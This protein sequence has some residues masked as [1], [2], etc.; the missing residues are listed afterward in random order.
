MKHSENIAEIAAALAKA[1]GVMAKAKRSGV[2]DHFRSRY[3]MLDDL[4]EVAR[5][6]LS[7][8]S[9]A[10]VQSAGTDPG[11]GLARVSTMLL[12]SSGQWMQSTVEYPVEGNVQSLGSTFTYLRRQSLSS[13]L[14]ISCDVD[15]DGEASRISGGGSSS[16]RPTPPPSPRARGP[17]LNTSGP[18]PAQAPEPAGAEVGDGYQVVQ[19]TIA[20]VAARPTDNGGTRYAVELEGFD[21]RWA[22]TFDEKLGEYAK[23]R[24]G[25]EVFAEVKRGPKRR[26][27]SGYLW[28]LVGMHQKD[29]KAQKAEKAAPA[30]AQDEIPF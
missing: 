7:G 9:I 8:V 27:G 23:A 12:H 1:Q 4:L 6:A 10:F 30:P 24:E 17:R 11:A 26:D 19:C 29:E 13:L 3:P 28:N 2:N 16:G 22:S 5:D 21:E 14:G 15:D 20:A 18:R 25:A